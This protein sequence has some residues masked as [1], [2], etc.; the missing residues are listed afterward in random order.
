MRTPPILMRAVSTATAPI[1]PIFRNWECRPA[2]HLLRPP[3]LG[4]GENSMSK[5]GL[6][7]VRSY[8]SRPATISDGVAV[9]CYNVEIHAR[10]G[11]NA[12]TAAWHV[13]LK[14]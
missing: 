2:V 13:V 12:I 6:E 3:R 1:C 4:V 10:T 9:S 5:R 7:A 8:Y 11:Q 14:E